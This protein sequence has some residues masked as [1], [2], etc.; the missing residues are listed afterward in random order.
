MIAQMYLFVWP[1][2][3][4]SDQG[5]RITGAQSRARHGTLKA[6]HGL[7]LRCI[8]RRLQAPV[9]LANQAEAQ[10]AVHTLPQF[11]SVSCALSKSCPMKA[12]CVRPRESHSR[13]LVSISIILGYHLQL[14]GLCSGSRPN[15]LERSCGAHV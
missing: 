12:R 11:A 2:R 4:M 9:P 7:L 1:S 6:R 3:K 8:Q 15:L 10:L 5:F 14:F 13:S